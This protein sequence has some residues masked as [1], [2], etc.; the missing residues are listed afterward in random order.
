MAM[1]CPNCGAEAHTRS[2]RYLHDKS[3]ERYLQCRNIECSATFRT[4]EQFVNY[5]SKPEKVGKVKK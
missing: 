3:I 1:K 5:V 2:S 4:L